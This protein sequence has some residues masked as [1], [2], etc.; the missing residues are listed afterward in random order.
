MCVQDLA[1]SDVEDEGALAEEWGAD[2]TPRLADAVRVRV[3]QL[4]RSLHSVDDTLG[5]AE[6]GGHKWH[7]ALV[8]RRR[9]VSELRGCLQHPTTRALCDDDGGSSGPRDGEGEERVA[10]L[11][12]PGVVGTGA[13]TT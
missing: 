9:I 4:V 10:E 1:D 12:L 3:Q 5:R 11:L 7:G 8:M 2:D 6:P 13:C